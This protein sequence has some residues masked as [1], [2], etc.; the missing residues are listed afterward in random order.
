MSEETAMF[1]QLQKYYALW[2]EYN[3]TY[4]HWAKEHGLSLNSI[5]VLYSF[6]EDRETCTQKTISQKWVIPKQ[7]VNAILKDFEKQE[8]VEFVPM[9]EDRRNKYIQLTETGKQYVNTIISE[10]RKI[11]L[12]VVKQMGFEC[13]ESLNDSYERF[14]VLFRKEVNKNG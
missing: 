1:E 7:T 8:F 6:Y 4:E 12:S 9:A 13:M 11:E 14:I 2:R 10:L 3:A 5:M